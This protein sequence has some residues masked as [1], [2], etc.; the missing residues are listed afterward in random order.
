[1]RQGN[2][3]M[4]KNKI[5]KINSLE[6]VDVIRCIEVTIFN[7]VAWISPGHSEGNSQDAEQRGTV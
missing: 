2:Y 3:T 6:E 4:I 1:M 5:N 7:D